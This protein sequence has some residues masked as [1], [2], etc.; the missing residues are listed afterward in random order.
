[1]QHIHNNDA[2]ELFPEIAALQAFYAILTH[3][4]KQLLRIQNIVLIFFTIRLIRKIGLAVFT[5][6]AE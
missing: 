6:I 1:M 2:E 4:L 3:F 5:L